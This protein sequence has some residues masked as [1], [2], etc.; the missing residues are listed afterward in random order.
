[1]SLLFPWLLLERQVVVTGQAAK[2]STAE[3]LRYFASRPHRSQ[4][5]AW[6]SP[7]SR[8]ISSRQLLEMEW[9][10]LKQKFSDGKI[11]LP[12]FWG[13]YRVTPETIEFWQG[14]QDRLH[15]RFQYVRQMNGSWTIDRLAP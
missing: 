6:A 13:G 1:M 10:R 4:L 9:E 8:V 2:I 7:Q 5:A 3:S 15:D 12:S 14:G 11:P